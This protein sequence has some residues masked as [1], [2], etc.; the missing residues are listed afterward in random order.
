MRTSKFT[1]FV[2]GMAVLLLLAGAQCF[3]RQCRSYQNCER[4]CECTD[5]SNG[6][7]IACPMYFS[8]DTRAGV[9]GDDY[10][11]SCD[12][13]CGRFAAREMCGTRPCSNEADCVREAVCRATDPQSGAVYCTYN[14]EFTFGCVEGAN[15]CEVDFGLDD[16][17]FCAR[18]CPIPTDGSCG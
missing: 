1:V 16:L 10:N 3:P 2:G 9:C 15:G 13:V 12:E 11:M 6:S 8:C 4:L 5:N 14:C 7:L 18:Y 17:T